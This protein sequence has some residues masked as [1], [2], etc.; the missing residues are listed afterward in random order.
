MKLVD[1]DIIRLKIIENGVDGKVEGCNYSYG[2]EPCGYTARL[3]N[4]YSMDNVE[5]KIEYGVEDLIML[6]NRP[7]I[8]STVEVLNMPK[9]VSGVIFCKSSLIRQGVAGF[10][11]AIEPGYK[12]NISALFYNFSCIPVILKVNQ[13]LIQFQF[14]LLEELPKSTYKGRYQNSIGVVKYKKNDK[15]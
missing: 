4:N 11:G 13:G 2:I 7:Y 12:G 1:L 8:L 14:D 10:F 6:P 5:Y 3:N 9:N 15:Q